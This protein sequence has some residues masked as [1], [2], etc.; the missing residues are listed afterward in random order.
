MVPHLS[1]HVP[2]WGLGSTG[3]AT[4]AVPPSCAGLESLAG[5]RCLAQL[6]LTCC[7]RLSDDKAL[8]VLPRVT[9]AN[10]QV[11]RKEG[12]Y[13]LAA[14]VGEE[15]WR[16]CACCLRPCSPACLGNSPWRTSTRTKI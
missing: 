2:R 10:V 7:R 3:S 9:A 12:K 13:C 4:C 6:D 5:L 15:G 1:N 14:F 11:S 8:A 16:G